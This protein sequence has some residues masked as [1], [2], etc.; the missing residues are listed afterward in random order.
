MM[1]AIRMAILRLFRALTRRDAE[2]R[3]SRAELDG[4][5]GSV[6]RGPQPIPA[7]DGTCKHRDGPAAVHE[8][9]LHKRNLE[10][11]LREQGVP[12]HAA[13]RA[14]SIMYAKDKE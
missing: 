12:Y 10:R 7:P 2:Q 6:S 3:G 8:M 14:V 9:A 13:K 1:Q 5:C 4:M 11:R